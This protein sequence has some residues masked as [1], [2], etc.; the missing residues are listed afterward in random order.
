MTDTLQ[1]LLNNLPVRKAA[2]RKPKRTYKYD[3]KQLYYDARR[4]MFQREYPTA[5]ASGEYYDNKIPDINTT[6]GFSRY[7]EDVINNMGHHAE[8]V[9]TMG[10]PTKNGWRRSGS[11]LGSPD[12]HCI[13]AGKTWKIEVKK[14]SDKL[15]KAQEKYQAKMKAIGVYHSVIYVGDADLFWD[16]Y[17]KII[18]S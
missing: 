8:R 14:G 10:I 3:L 18:A 7:I 13:V 4:L 2:K 11:T 5:W 17:Y 6:N 1:D 15:N 9:N 16:E 12:L